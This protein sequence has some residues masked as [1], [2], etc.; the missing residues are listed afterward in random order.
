M[1]IAIDVMGG[2]N[3]PDQIL[4]GALDALSLLDTDDKLILVGN[5]DVIVPKIPTPQDGRIQVE[6]AS[7][8]IT[9]DD[10][11]VEAIRGKRDSS[12]VRMVKLGKEGQADA[13]IS[14]GNTGA[15]V[16]AGV[17]MLKPLAG[18]DRPG[19]ACFLP[20]A[21]GGVLLCDAGANIQPKSLHL[22]QYAV[23]GSIYA[24][25]LG[26]E[27]PTVG[28]LN[29]GTEDEKGTPL[30]KEA[31]GLIVADPLINFV[32]Y[33]EGRD[34]P[35]HPC[36]VLITDGF[37]G[38]VTLKA[39]EGF[40]TAVLRAIQ[41]EAVADVELAGKLKPLLGRALKQYDH[42]EAGGALLL[43]VQGMFFKV[44]GSGGARAIKSAV[45]SVKTIGKLDVNAAIEQRLQPIT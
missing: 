20:S 17:L 37:T 24:R 38:N 27:N 3:A 26:K 14:A 25:A 13:M 22:Y 10:S 23:I 44:H 43:G 34:I 35:K 39:V 36:D 1:R 28:I 30:V 40:T 31:K 16:A 19:L 21:K 42:E 18:V 4:A 45:A 12:I 41:K 29:I 33:V 9:M 8:V 11:P 15:L 7:Q 6:H 2:D 32:G 5:Q